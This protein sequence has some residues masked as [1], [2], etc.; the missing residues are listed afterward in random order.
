MTFCAD[1]RGPQCHSAGMK[2]SIVLCAAL[3]L[4]GC[5]I[6]TASTAAAGATLKKQEL[7]QAGR[8]LQAVQ[9]RI[10]EAMEHA[11]RREGAEQ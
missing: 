4:A 7:E 8:N 5:G 1:G 10:V 11:E 9:G 6:E 3:A 2:T